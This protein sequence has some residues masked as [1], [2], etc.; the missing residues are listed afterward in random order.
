MTFHGSHYYFR[1][2]E[3]LIQESM[4]SGEFDNLGKDQI[5]NNNPVKILRLLFPVT[6]D[7]LLHAVEYGEQSTTILGK[8]TL[9]LYRSNLL[10]GGLK[11]ISN[12]LMGG[13]KRIS[14]TSFQ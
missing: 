5:A 12:L 8:G 3:D 11:R 6:H 10:M 4:A 7:F 13:L 14:S 2:V 9:N 1:L